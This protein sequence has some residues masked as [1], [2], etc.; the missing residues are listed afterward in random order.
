[1]DL[2]AAFQAF[3]IYSIMAFSPQDEDSLI[4]QTTLINLQEFASRI[5]QAGLVC[6]A[7]LAHTRPHWKSWIVAS[8]KRRTL[9]AMYMF[10]NAVNTFNNNPVYIAVELETLPAPASKALWEARKREAWEREYDLYLGNWEGGGL[11]LGELW[12]L[13]TETGARERR[14]RVDKWVE[15][16]DEFGMMLLAVCMHTHGC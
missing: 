15:S 8:A 16:V 13:E 6:Q 9:F 10:D 4:D 2:L 12:L 3:L 1:M 14:E 7:E 5:S 11:R